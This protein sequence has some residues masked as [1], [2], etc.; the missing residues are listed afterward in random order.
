MAQSKDLFIKLNFRIIA[1]TASSKII[2]QMESVEDSS[3]V[4]YPIHSTSLRQLAP[5]Q[6]L[7]FLIT[8]MI[9]VN[10]I[11]ITLALEQEAIIITMEQMKHLWRLSKVSARPTQNS[12]WHQERSVALSCASRPILSCKG[13]ASQTE[14]ITIQG[15]EISPPAWIGLWPFQVRDIDGS[16]QRW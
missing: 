11:M 14:R 10:K 16:G 8:P 6:K 12:F 9:T 5:W 15:P 4:T 3:L 7:L 13:I 2:Q 1:F